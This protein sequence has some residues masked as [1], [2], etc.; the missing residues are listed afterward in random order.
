[1]VYNII[2]ELCEQDN[3]V[4]DSEYSVSGGCDF[5]LVHDI[6]D[7]VSCDPSDGQLSKH[8]IVGTHSNKIAKDYNDP[9][10][11]RGFLNHSQATFTFNGPDRDP[12]RLH[13]IDKYL[14][15]AEVIRGSGCPNYREA[16]IPI[17]SSLNIAAW[18]EHLQGYFD[19]FLI[20][21]LKFGFPLSLKCPMNLAKTDITNHFSATSEAK[22]VTKYIEKEIE[23]GAMLVFANK[24]SSSHFHY[25]P[26]LTRPKENNKR[27]VILNLS[28][29]PGH[30]LNDKVDRLKFDNWNFTFERDAICNK[31]DPVLFKVDIAHA[32][33]TSGLIL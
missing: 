2:Y 9:S 10:K 18:E 26:M 32:F 33:K 29:P 3:N 15:V 8:H 6:N 4:L 1:M 28:P 31:Q 17:V 13:S 14:Q 30:S 19:K 22:A 7:C 23:L 20:Q 11:T 27:R 21:S 5:N 24:V 25:S 16:C 12:I